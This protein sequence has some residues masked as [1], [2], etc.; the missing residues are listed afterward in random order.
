MLQK[1]EIRAGLIGLLARIQT[2]LF[3][4]GMEEE[5]QQFAIFGR[6]AFTIRYSYCVTCFLFGNPFRI[7]ILALRYSPGERRPRLNDGGEYILHGDCYNITYTKDEIA[8]FQG[9][10]FEIL[11]YFACFEV[12]F[13]EGLYG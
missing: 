3:I 4:E 6:C 13:L 2:C 1:P 11:P 12:K 9:S 10:L 8:R 5:F 7:K